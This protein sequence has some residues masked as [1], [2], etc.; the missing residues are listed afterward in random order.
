MKKKAFTLAEVLITLAIIGVVAA[1]TIPSIVANH[2]KRTLETQFAKAYRTLQTAFN[3]AASQ[4]GSIETWDWQE[5][6]TEEDRDNFVKKYLSSYLNVAKFCSAKERG[7][8]CSPDV[9]HKWKNGGTHS[10]W[11]KQPSPRIILADGTVILALLNATAGAMSL[12]VDLNGAKKPNVIGKDTFHFTCFSYS[13]EFL[14]TGIN[15]SDF[16]SEAGEY[17]KNTYEVIKSSCADGGSGLDCSALIVM[18]GFK[19]NYDW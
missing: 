17:T 14:P 6:Y 4:H 18:D 11:N 3:L 7:T 8:K 9:T 10:N 19:I 1:I 5:T 2:Q 16:D 15:G 13:G 12:Y